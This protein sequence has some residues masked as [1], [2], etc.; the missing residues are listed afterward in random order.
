MLCLEQLLWDEADHAELAERRCRVFRI[1][2][3]KLYGITRHIG[4]L[5]RDTSDLIERRK[6]Q[7]DRIATGAM[8]GDRIR[9]FRAVDRW[10][11]ALLVRRIRDWPVA[12]PARVAFSN[13]SAAVSIRSGRR[14]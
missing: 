5:R 9:V 10:N 11:V 12:V 3:E 13:L 8:V 14:A 6:L 2:K 7:C 4:E 1:R